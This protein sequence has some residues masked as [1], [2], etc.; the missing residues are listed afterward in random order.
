MVTLGMG[1]IL[2]S[3]D[4]HLYN[5]Q[6]GARN[7]LLAPFLTGWT[8]CDEVHDGKFAVAVLTV[9]AMW[10]SVDKQLRSCQDWLKAG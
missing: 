9:C 6:F 4:F 3:F 10:H 7:D 1:A 8:L 5:L 2:R